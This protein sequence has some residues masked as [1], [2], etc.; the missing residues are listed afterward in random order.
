MSTPKKRGRP[1]TFKRD[2]TVALAMDNYWKEGLHSMSVNEICRRIRISK[3]SLYREFGDEDGLRNAALAHYAEQVIAP[4]AGLVDPEHSFVDNTERILNNITAPD[5]QHP[6]CLFVKMRGA[7]AKLGPQTLARIDAMVAMVESG[8]GRMVA[9]A[10]ARGE[11][12]DDIDDAFAARYVDTQMSLV[13]QRVA[14]GA[15]AAEARAIGRLALKALLV[16][17]G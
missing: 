7:H 6:G 15:D 4:M 9:R 11:V 16:Q 17:S 12:R 3:P 1:R 5:R 10:K 14:D 13:L 2:H 8:Y